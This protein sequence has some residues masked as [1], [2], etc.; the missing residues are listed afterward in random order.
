MTVSGLNVVN[1]VDDPFTVMIEV[2]AEVF[3]GV[4]LA[5]S[6]DHQGVLVFKIDDGMVSLPVETGKSMLA[7]P[8]E[9][10]VKGAVPVKVAETVVGVVDW[11]TG[12]RND[13]AS[14]R[15]AEAAE[16]S[17]TFG[18]DVGT[19]SA[20]ATDAS[21]NANAA[22]ETALSGSD[23]TILVL[24]SLHQHLARNNY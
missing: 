1:V 17:T 9:L 16:G 15:A 13:A 23:G 12:N 22:S 8:P 7:V 5:K 14:D 6:D 20:S 24:L 21:D 18:V 19:A 10:K 11:E 4:V 2:K 3:V